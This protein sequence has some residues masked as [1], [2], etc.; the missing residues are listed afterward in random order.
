MQC[1]GL[2]AVAECRAGIFQCFPDDL[3]GRSLLAYGEWLPELIEAMAPLLKPG[4]AVVEAAPGIGAH[5]ADIARRIAP[6]GHLMVF[7]PR[8]R[9][10]RLLTQNLSANLLVNVTVLK[11]ALWNEPEPSTSVPID[12]LDDY[13]LDRLH[14]LKVTEA[15]TVL[16][17]LAGA[18]ETLWRLRPTMLLAADDEASALAIRDAVR[19]LGFRGWLHE[20]ALYRS[21]NFNQRSEDIFGRKRTLAVIALPEESDAD[22]AA[23]GKCKE[24]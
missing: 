7:E 2:S 12:R 1:R 3:V 17:V 23:L 11:R 14:L 20:T 15:F 13:A 16:P 5:A 21:S 19:P 22:L 24:L 9:M 6:S 4:V 8:D 10:H 18:A